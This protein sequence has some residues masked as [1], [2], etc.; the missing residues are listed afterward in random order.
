MNQPNRFAQWLVC[1]Q[2]L[3]SVL[4]T[5][6]FLGRGVTKLRDQYR[7]HRTR[8]EMYSGIDMD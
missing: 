7:A 6:V 8:L 4:F 5:V 3:I 2:M 1:V